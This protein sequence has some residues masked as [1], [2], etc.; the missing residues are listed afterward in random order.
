M[1][2]E[3]LLSFYEPRGILNSDKVALL[4]RYCDILLEENRH[5]NLTAIKEV[6]DVVEKHFF[7]C[8]LPTLSEYFVGK[9]FLDVGSGAGFPGL[10]WAIAFPERHFVLLDATA[11]RCR[12]LEKVVDEL[13]LNNVEVVNC[14]AEEYQKRNAFDVVTARAVSFL[15][16]LLEITAPFAKDGGL[17][18]AMKGS[19]ADEEI[20]E[21]KNAIKTLNLE[22]VA[23]VEDTLPNGD[24]RSNIFI[25]RHGEIPAKYPRSWAKITAKP[26]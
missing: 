9:T 22:L 26:L 14:R 16:V 20:R 25:R 8:L 17:I 1:T 19:K 23:N 10:V 13:K 24:P 3:E 4:S 11:K 7:D 6:P 21:A 15:P 12:F 2:Y 18:L 5:Y